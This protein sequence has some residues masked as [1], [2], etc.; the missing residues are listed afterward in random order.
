MTSRREGHQSQRNIR[1][2]SGPQ[3]REH[4]EGG[5][6]DLWPKDL[7]GGKQNFGDDGTLRR[8]LEPQE[9][10]KPRRG[11]Q[12]FEGKALRDCVRLS[13]LSSLICLLITE[14]GRENN[15]TG[16]NVHLQLKWL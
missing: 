4:L 2:E 14:T 9:Q 12:D 16:I 11:T 15:S 3:G 13:N 6:H 5:N 8:E 7:R 10:E 1:R